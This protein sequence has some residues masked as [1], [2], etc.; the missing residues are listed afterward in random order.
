[1][2]EG[3]NRGKG[4]KEAWPRGLRVD[5]GGRAVSAVRW[6]ALDFCGP[7]LT[8]CCLSPS[9]EFTHTL[10]EREVKPLNMYI[11]LYMLFTT[12]DKTSGEELNHLHP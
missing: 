2:H 4:Q 10:D 11:Q 5:K 1:M 12:I 7:L 9:V 6:A 3:Y 8:R